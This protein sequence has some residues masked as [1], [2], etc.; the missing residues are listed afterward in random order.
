MYWAR[1][2][3]EAAERGIDE[4]LAFFA[5]RGRR[6][7]WSIGP[8]S[9]PASLA[10]RLERGGFTLEAD[11]L[12]LAARLPVPG[13]RADPTLRIEP[14]R[15]EAIARAATAIEFEHLSEADRERIASD[16][17]A[18]V[19]ADDI[20]A[21]VAYRAGTVVA[22]ARW[23]L[24]PERRAVHLAGSFTLPEHRGRGAYS[25]LVAYRTE[26]ARR[27]GCEYATITADVAT[28]APILLKR[29]FVA[30]GKERIYV[31]APA[32]EALSS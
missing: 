5:A 3:D 10:E 28:S 1:W 15:D 24:H 30:L 13:L 9:R 2:T 11:T 12:W 14:V 21:V 17:L 27:A 25:A 4:V 16:L 18:R 32:R 6:F 22:T 26:D 8:S 7:I 31:W 20:R 23:R 19:R 29:G